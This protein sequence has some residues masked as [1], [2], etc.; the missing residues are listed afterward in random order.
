ML[1]YSYVFLPDLGRSAFDMGVKCL[2]FLDM[3]W[4]TD[5]VSAFF[6]PE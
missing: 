6:Y 2:N 5:I 3:L 4:I 1:V